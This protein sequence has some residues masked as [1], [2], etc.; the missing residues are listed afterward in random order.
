MES[1][2]DSNS[3]INRQPTTTIIK[4]YPHYD[5]EI[6]LS[7]IHIYDTTSVDTLCSK[8]TEPFIHKPEETHMFKKNVLSDLW[9]CCHNLTCFARKKNKLCFCDCSECEFCWS[10]GTIVCCCSYCDCNCICDSCQTPPFNFCNY[11]FDWC[12]NF[13]RYFQNC[14]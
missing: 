12:C 10:C 4:S 9:L 3:T 8:N 5:D 13:L 2:G 1:D 6:D 14:F 7:E 11:K